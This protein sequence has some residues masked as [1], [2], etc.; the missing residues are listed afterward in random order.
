MAAT[1]FTAMTRA[2][3]LSGTRELVEGKFIITYR[4]DERAGEVVVVSV[5]HGARRR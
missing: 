2:G 5:V 3:R 1:G 4:H